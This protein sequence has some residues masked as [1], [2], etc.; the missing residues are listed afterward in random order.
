MNI[1]TERVPFVIKT[2]NNHH[3]DKC[4]QYMNLN[5]SPLHYFDGFILSW[6]MY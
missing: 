4:G 6:N 5:N 3:P 1:V 2:I